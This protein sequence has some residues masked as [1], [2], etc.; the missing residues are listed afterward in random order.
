MALFHPQ[1][2]TETPPHKAKWVKNKKKGKA[3][4]KKGA[5]KKKTGS[6]IAFV[7]KAIGSGHDD[8]KEVAV[9]PNCANTDEVGNVL[10]MFCF[11]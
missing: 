11:E 5:G 8:K 7:K 10:S 3:A 1:P 6:N 9:V 4:P 2:A